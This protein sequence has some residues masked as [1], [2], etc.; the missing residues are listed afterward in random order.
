MAASS[1][2]TSPRRD[3]A[4][5]V[6]SVVS[7]KS[8]LRLRR[9][10]RYILCH[11]HRIGVRMRGAKSGGRVRGSSICLPLHVRSEHLHHSLTRAP[12]RPSS[13]HLR[14]S[15]PP[16]S[17]LIIRISSRR[18]RRTDFEDSRALACSWRTISS[19]SVGNEPLRATTRRW[20]AR[21]WSVLFP[22]CCPTALSRAS[23]HIPHRRA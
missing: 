8:S 3:P 9:T 23:P 20:Q 5:V 17:H 2:V 21:A 4:S 15:P 18:R 12:T 6:Q 22:P 19:E 13:H 11:G 16:P 14:P 1:S 7:P 10:T